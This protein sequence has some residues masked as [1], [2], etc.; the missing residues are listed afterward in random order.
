[1]TASANKNRIQRKHSLGPIP[2]QLPVLDLCSVP[3]LSPTLKGPLK[4][5]LLMQGENLEMIPGTGAPNGKTDD[6]IALTDGLMSGRGLLTIDVTH[7][8]SVMETTIGSMITRVL[9]VLRLLSTDKVTTVLP[10]TMMNGQRLLVLRITSRHPLRMAEM[11]DGC[12]YRPP[13]LF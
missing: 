3:L 1:M 6:T 12:H 10:D 4:K 7:L 2:T 8:I 13:L 11:I 9:V 5:D